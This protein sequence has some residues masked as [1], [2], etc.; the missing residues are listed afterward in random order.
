[1]K[2]QIST[3]RI[4]FIKLQANLLDLCSTAPETVAEGQDLDA[5]LVQPLDE[6][7]L[8][9]ARRKKREAIKAKYKGQETPALVQAL[10]LNNTTA[11]ASPKD[12]NSIVQNSLQADG[13]NAL[14]V[15]EDGLT[16]S[17]LQI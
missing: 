16:N 6:A 3:S 1:M 12:P 8:I 5:A 11:P 15:Q 17:Y 14:E 13:K 9:E 2:L 7:A 4:S 10:A